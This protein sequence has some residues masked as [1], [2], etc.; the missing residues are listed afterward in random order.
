MDKEATWEFSPNPP[1]Y[2]S[3]ALFH[4]TCIKRQQQQRLLFSLSLLQPVNLNYLKLV[5]AFDAVACLVILH[6]INFFLLALTHK[7]Y[8]KRVDRPGS[9]LKNRVINF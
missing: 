2:L 6:V 5:K 1:I 7:T 4:G 9:A 8:K 3:L